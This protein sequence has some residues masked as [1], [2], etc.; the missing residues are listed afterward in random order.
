MLFNIER[1]KWFITTSINVLFIQV[2]KDNPKKPTHCAVHINC[3]IYRGP[4]FTLCHNK[5]RYAPWPLNESLHCSPAGC[6]FIKTPEEADLEPDNDGDNS[7]WHE[8][9][10]FGSCSF[11]VYGIPLTIDRYLCEILEWSDF[12]EVLDKFVIQSTVSGEFSST[13]FGVRKKT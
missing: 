1:M 12:V 7:S 9:G 11:S 2:P 8:S 10:Y 4:L 3:V 13:F 5:A 6:L